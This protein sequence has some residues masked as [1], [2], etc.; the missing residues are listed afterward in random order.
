[1]EHIGRIEQPADGPCP[2]LAL[3]GEFD[4]SNAPELVERFDE[5]AERGHTRIVVDMSETSFIDSTVLGAFGLAYRRGLHLTIR[6][7]ADVVR[8]QLDASGLAAIFDIE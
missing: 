2:I 6:G 5:L 7:A 8:R 1:M 3:V 4:L